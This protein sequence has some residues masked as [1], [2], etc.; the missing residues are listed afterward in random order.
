MRINLFSFLSLLIVLPATLQAYTGAVNSATA[1]AGSAA[2]EASENPYGNPAALGFLRGYYFTAGFGSTNQK[3]IGST[4]DLAVSL[5]DNMKDTVVPTALS[6]VQTNNRPEKS[7]EFQERQFRLGLGNIIAPGLGFGLGVT[8]NDDRLVGNRVTQTNLDTGFLYA[9]NRDMSASVLLENLLPPDGD[10]IEA[11]RLKQ[12]M[13]LGASYNH[14]KFARFKADIISA[15]NNSF[16]RPTLAAGVESY[17]NKWLIVR[18]GLQRNNQK[19][20]N[21]YA[22]GLGF[23][24]PKFALHYAYQNSPQDESLTRHS[25]D[26]AVPIW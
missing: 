15:D 18:W 1:G 22:G 3:M 13:T 17:L 10:V 2:I 21:V 14:K 11:Y 9:P 19:E 7:E 8:H 4:Q 20:A 23:I 16:D 5:S 24:G 6:Y 25:V 26:M 12:T